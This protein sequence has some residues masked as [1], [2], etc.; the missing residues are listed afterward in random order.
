MPD[1]LLFFVTSAVIALTP[2]PS[3]I[4]VI[5]RTVTQGSA[6]GL[7]AV[8]GNTTGIAVHTIGVALGLSLLIR[9]SATAFLVLKVVGVFYLI[10]LALRTLRRG[11]RTDGAQPRSGGLTMIFAEAVMVNVT[12]PK[13]ALLFIALLPHFIDPAGAV[14]FQMLLLGA[15]HMA[16]ATIVTTGLVILA[17]KLRTAL[18]GGGRGERLF[19]WGAGSALLLLAGKLAFAARG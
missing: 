16:V 9:E 13:V 12:N 8:A 19:R 17:K 11:I 15:V 10:Y 4:Y 1:L 7:A 6:A 14:L 3:W 2:G 18:V 5:S